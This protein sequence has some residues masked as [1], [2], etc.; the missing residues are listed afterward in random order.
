MVGRMLNKF[1]KYYYENICRVTK[2]YRRPLSIDEYISEIKAE[3]KSNNDF[4][5][6]LITA[7]DL[8]M[9]S[10]G[11]LTYDRGG[12]SGGLLERMI[13]KA[14]QFNW[15]RPIFFV[16]PIS[17]EIGSGRNPF[18]LFGNLTSIANHRNKNRVDILKQAKV[19]GLV[20]V[21][22]HGLH[23]N[24]ITFRGYYPF[25]EFEFSSLENDRQKISTMLKIFN[26]AGLP[27]TLFK[28]PAFSIGTSRHKNF[29]A[30][31][32]QYPL[33]KTIFFSSPTNGLNA[34]CKTVSHIHEQKLGRLINVPQ[35]I[36]LCWSE[37]EIDRVIKLIVE[38]RGIIHIQFHT[39]AESVLEDGFSLKNFM[40]IKYCWE[41]ALHHSK[42]RIE[43]RTYE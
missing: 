41:R 9:T 38:K 11:F 6:F 19:E 14:N 4:V 24:Q 31:V 10:E 26:D 30:T 18:Q 40:K 36:N 35:N 7:D 25:A 34:P 2:P 39:I 12:M 3:I 32:D 15:F 28:P 13:E 22:M 16:I 21:G 17:K 8:S 1:L 27:S 29:I 33:I 42:G 37:G 43:V 5:Q 23:H 20:S